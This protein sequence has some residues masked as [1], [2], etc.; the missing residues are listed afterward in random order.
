M[1][2][3]QLIFKHKSFYT[4]E[5]TKSVKIIEHLS[6]TVTEYEIFKDFDLIVETLSLA[7]EACGFDETE[8]HTDYALE[9]IKNGGIKID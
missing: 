6:E 4:N 9:L 5:E 8:Q 1:E 7:D 3:L 2:K